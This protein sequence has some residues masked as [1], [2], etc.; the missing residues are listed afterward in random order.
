M[1]IGTLAKAQ[2]MPACYTPHEEEPSMSGTPGFECMVNEVCIPDVS[3]NYQNTPNLV[4]RLNYHFLRPTDGSG[5]HAGDQSAQVAAEVAGLNDHFGNI[6]PPVLPTQPPAAYID[7]ARVRFVLEG[8]YY[9]DDDDRYGYYYN[10]DPESC[11]ASVM[12]PEFGVD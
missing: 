5:L 12:N 3:N 8:V 1:L 9:Q 7:D 11:P 6:Q 4:F 2:D 10:Y